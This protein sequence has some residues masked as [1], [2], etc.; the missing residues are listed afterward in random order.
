M[1]DKNDTKRREDSASNEADAL[2]RSV[3]I[4]PAI[5]WSAFKTWI[6]RPAQTIPALA[7]LAR[8]PPSWEK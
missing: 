2:N 7:E 6:E 3:V 8:R 1:A 4:I 5:D